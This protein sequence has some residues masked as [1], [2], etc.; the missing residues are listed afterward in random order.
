[1]GGVLCARLN[2]KQQ[3][4]TFKCDISP[5]FCGFE[6]VV[7]SYY[8]NQTIF[9]QFAFDLYASVIFWIKLSPCLKALIPGGKHPTLK[10]IIL[11]NI[12]SMPHALLGFNACSL[13][14]IYCLGSFMLSMIY[15]V[16]LYT[17]PKWVLHMFPFFLQLFQTLLVFIDS[18]IA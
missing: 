3:A 17:F 2:Q 12:P 14:F 11:F 10:T 9:T 1:L 13:S 18:S 4:K 7:Q 15:S 8:D 6:K 16:V 5:G